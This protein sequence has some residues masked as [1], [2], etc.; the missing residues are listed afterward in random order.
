MLETWPFLRCGTEMFE[1]YLDLLSD[2][3]VNNFP[4]NA[5]TLTLQIGMLQS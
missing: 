2:Q 5:Y 1:I 4:V 3:A